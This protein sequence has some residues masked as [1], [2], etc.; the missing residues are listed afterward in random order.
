MPSY[1]T[2]FYCKPY[3]IRAI[4]TYCFRL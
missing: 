3:T 4:I 1:R 2:A